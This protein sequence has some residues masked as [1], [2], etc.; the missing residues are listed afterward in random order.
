MSSS[1]Q[2]QVR[3]IREVTP[4]T[5]PAGNMTTAP[6][7]E[8]SFTGE[9]ERETPGDVR[10]DREPT[11]NPATGFTPGATGSCDFAY[12]NHD[13]E[14]GGAF[15]REK[16]A[17]ESV[18]AST[19]AFAASGNTITDSGNGLDGFAV[20][21]FVF[22]TGATTNG[23]A[24]VIGPVLTVAAGALT[25]S[26]EFKT[27]VDEAAGA[28][29]TVQHSGLF[30]PGT[31]LLTATYEIWNTSTSKGQ[32]MAWLG[33][34]QWQFTV[35]HPN[36]CRESFTFVGGALPVRIGTQLANGTTAGAFNPG[37]NSNIHFGDAANPTAGLGLR[38]GGTAIQLRVKNLQVTLANPLAADGGAGILGPQ[39]IALDGLRSVRVDITFTRT[40]SADAE[41][42]I[43]DA[44]DPNVVS[45]FA[46]GFRD[47][48]GRRKLIYL[49]EAQPGGGQGTGVRQSGR[50]EFTVNLMARR[51]ASW[52]SIRVA[53]F[54]A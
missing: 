1:S 31:S 12:A 13:L 42:F 16:T 14:V 49:P 5:T 7:E 25:F 11:D 32:S 18:T 2:N 40:G 46:I 30:Y 44:R 43:D 36:R 27:L 17:P 29:I 21:D 38:W 50:D 4:G 41:D 37:M 48:A 3:R 23:G 45:S 6:W 24:F 8:F 22:V 34:S 47:G 10:A 53:D 51:S 9:L 54:A 15:C 35:P 26:T 19:I 52:G 20:G 39:D 33:V 28:S